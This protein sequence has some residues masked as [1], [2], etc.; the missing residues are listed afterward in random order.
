MQQ[1]AVYIFIIIVIAWVLWQRIIGPKMSG[2]KSI[3]AASYQQMRNQPHTLVDVRQQGEW[4]SGH[5][6]KASHI[7]LGEIKQRMDEIAKDK[8]VVVICASGGRSSMAAT[9]LANAGYSEVYNFSGGMG[10]WS[11]ANLPVSRGR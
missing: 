8:P 10:A 4:E 1:N 9:A 3:N 7:P 11:S 2:V 6:A 5:A